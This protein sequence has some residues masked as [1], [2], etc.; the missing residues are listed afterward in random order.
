MQTID[1][2]GTSLLASAVAAGLVAAGRADE[3]EQ[4]RRLHPEVAEALVGAGFARHLVP[5]RWGGTAGGYAELAE[6]VAVVGEGCASAGW[7]AA[8]YAIAGRIGAHLPLAGQEE[9]WGD[10]PDVLIASGIVP[11]PGAG[12]ESVPGGGWRLTGEWPFSSGVGS[13]SWVVVGALVGADGGG[14]EFRFFAVPQGSFTVRRTWANVGL[15]GTG[16]DTVVLSDV[17]VPGHRTFRY[18][19]L[20]R[21]EAVGSTAVVHTV[22]YKLVNGLMFV[23]PALGAAR[24]ALRH[25]TEWI[26]SKYEMGGRPSRERGSVQ[27]ALARTSS[28][29]DLA[30]MLVARA[31]DAADLGDGSAETLAR[32]PRD[33]AVTADLLTSATTRLLR[34]GGARA[35]TAANPVQRAWRDVHAAAGHV[36]LQFDAAAAGYAEQVFGTA[37]AARG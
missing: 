17:F 18:D 27:E 19:A 10:G 3:A 4:D 33:F 16:S 13:A 8:V 6:A 32:S 15:G 21:G 25:W 36:V 11:A 12:V 31:A 9:L 28:E 23:S 20:L 7:C 37:P 29:L 26:G 30:G 34:A 35:Q 24:G 5:A 2:T 14:R 22:P 1:Q